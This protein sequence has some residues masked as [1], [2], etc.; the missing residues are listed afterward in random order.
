MVTYEQWNKAIISY[1]FEEY[2][3]P[4]Q[5]VF[6]QTDADTLYEIAEKSKFDLSNSDEAAD[7]LKEAVRDK[8][9]Y[10]D[11]VDFWE[12][13]PTKSLLR[14]SSVE[15]EPPQVAFLALTVLSA[16]LMDSEGSI[17]A[18]NYYIRLNELLF[19]QSFGGAPPGF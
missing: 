6:L 17:A 15:E 13:N 2:D 7:S 1:F 12:I 4:D 8:V 18:N 9:V 3:D 5:I 10:N 16:S 19:G 14:R 11:S